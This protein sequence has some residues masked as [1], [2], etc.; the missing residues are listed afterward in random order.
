MAQVK[1]ISIYK[2]L[3]LIY[4]TLQ[5]VSYLNSQNIYMTNIT[6]DTFITANHFKTIQLKD[7]T[8]CTKLRNLKN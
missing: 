8:Y 4:Q 1:P 3:Y 2:L 6:P 7:A 5:A